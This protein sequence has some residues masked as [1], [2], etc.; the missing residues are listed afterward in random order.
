[1]ITKYVFLTNHNTAFPF[2]N[3]PMLRGPPLPASPTQYTPVHTPGPRA[4]PPMPTF[5]QVPTASQLS[6]WM[7]PAQERLEEKGLGLSQCLSLQSKFVTLPSFY[8]P[9]PTF[10]TSSP[11][12]P[13]PCLLLDLRTLV[14]AS[15]K[16]TS[17]D[18]MQ[19]H[20]RCVSYEQ[21]TGWILTPACPWARHSCA[22]HAHTVM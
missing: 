16:G 1:M 13:P 3:I 22:E 5:L 2:S 9:G 10:F 18:W 7:F 11:T 4:G 21:G 19:P 8:I 20:A 6:V 15:E 17:S 12:P 14:C